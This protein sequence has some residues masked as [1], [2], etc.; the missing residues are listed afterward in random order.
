MALDDVVG[1]NSQV[2]VIL[3]GGEPL[4]GADAN[5]RLRDAGEN[6]TGH[7]ALAEHVVAACD[8][9]ERA[10]RRHP[11]GG[12]G[13]RDDILAQDRPQRRASV[14]AARERRRAGAFQLDVVANAVFT[15]DLAEQNGA[16][17]AELRRKATELV[18]GVSHGQGLGAVGNLV[19]RKDGETFRRI[20][21]SDVDPELGR[22][23]VVQ[24]DHHRR[25]DRGRFDRR[26]ERVRQTGVAVVKVKWHEAEKKASDVQPGNS[27]IAF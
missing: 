1:E 5:V 17:V 19:A 3:A 14:A 4:K 11:E 12:H 22:Q 26:E 18:P 25:A 8:G 15:D 20:E 27:N 21:P 24:P 6:S 9:G 16:A 13:F 10:G 7:H 2:V 23:V